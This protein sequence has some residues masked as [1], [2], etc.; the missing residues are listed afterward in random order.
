MAKSQGEFSSVIARL[1]SVTP[2]KGFPQ[3]RN[4]G[5]G[6]LALK[7]RVFPEGKRKEPWPGAW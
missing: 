3:N 7:S 2:G 1:S 6:F 5:K 4:C